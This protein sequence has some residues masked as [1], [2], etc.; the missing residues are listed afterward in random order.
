ME[1]DNMP[2]IEYRGFRDLVYAEVL[3]DTPEE[4]STGEVKP[5]VPAGEIAKTIE[6]SS[7]TKFYDNLAALVINSRGADTATLTTAVIPLGVQA[8]ITGQYL[9]EETGAFAEGSFTKAKYFALGYKIGEVGD[10]GEGDDPEM[11]VWRYK[12]TF[13]I[14]DVAAK[15]RDA[16]TDSSGQQLVYTGINTTHKFTKGGSAKAVAVR[17]ADNKVDV[18]TFFDEVTDIDKLKPLHPEG[19]PG[20]PA[21]AP[22]GKT[23]GPNDTPTKTEEPKTLKTAA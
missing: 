4:Y 15:T 1:N 19:E 23:T 17:T 3:K 7:A 13:N 10:T 6:Q 16:G 5:L 22:V 12:G 14:P 11:Y 8:E 2:V 20:E 18:S 21:G 9:D